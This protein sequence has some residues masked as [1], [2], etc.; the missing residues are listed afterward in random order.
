AETSGKVFSLESHA[1]IADGVEGQTGKSSSQNLAGSMAPASPTAPSQVSAPAAAAPA[2]AQPGMTAAT[3]T[4][5]AAPDDVADIVTSR[6][7][8][9]ERPDRISVQLDPPE[10]G[11]VSIEFKFDGQTLQH[12]AVTGDSPE[13][14]TKLR[15]MHFQLIQSL[16]QHGLSARDMTFSQNASQGDRHWGEPGAQFGQEAGNDTQA[17]SPDPQQGRAPPIRLASAGLNIKL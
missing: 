1:E 11:R 13:A 4:L 7:S 8:G 5:I 6:L 17:A 14:M 3:G 12:V 16:E 10:L 9:G 15:Q 2:P